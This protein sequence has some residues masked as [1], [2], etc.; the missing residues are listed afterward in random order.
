[1]LQVRPASPLNHGEGNVDVQNISLVTVWNLGRHTLASE[2]L[3]SNIEEALLEL[4]S[5]GHDMEF[6]FGKLA[7][8]PEVSDDDKC[9]DMSVPQ[10]V[11]SLA[12]KMRQRSSHH[13]NQAKVSVSFSTLEWPRAQISKGEDP[14]LDLEDHASIETSCDGRGQFSLLVNIENSKEVPKARVLR[15]LERATFSKVPGST[16]CLNRCADLSRYTKT[17]AL[18]D[19]SSGL[20]DSTSGTLLSVGD[21]AATVVQ[22]EGQYFLAIIQINEILFDTYPVLEISPRLLVEPTVTVQFQIY[23][24][25]ETSQDDLDVDGTNWKWNR[26]LEHTIL[27]TAGSFIQVI[28]PAIAIPEV[29]T[30]IY[31]FR[32]DELRAIAACLFSSVTVQDRC[33]LLRFLKRSSHFPYRTT[34]GKSLLDLQGTGCSLLI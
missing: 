31:Y 13:S 27:K 9:D 24:I 14:I 1:V 29:N 30:P 26:K 7:E 21:P 18:P 16:D 4:E 17:S 5:K 19:L 11:Q 6:P 34:N 23:Q 22:S 15:E 20:V 25:I 8:C 28:S 3:A 12:P 2:F 33:R 10:P 32:T